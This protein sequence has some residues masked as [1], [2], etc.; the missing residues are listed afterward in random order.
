MSLADYSRQRAG[1][2]K[3]RH[4][5]DDFAYGHKCAPVFSACSKPWRLDHSKDS[6]PSRPRPDY[7]SYVGRQ[8]KARIDLPRSPAGSNGFPLPSAEF[9]EYA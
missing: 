9:I 6:S 3:D 2:T 7:G 5:A 1:K 8:V 4:H